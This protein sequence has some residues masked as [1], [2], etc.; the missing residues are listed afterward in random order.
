MQRS[1][2]SVFSENLATWSICV[3][4]IILNQLSVSN[5]SL[6]VENS[7]STLYHALNGMRSEFNFL[8]SKFRL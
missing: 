7:N 3:I 8:G 2:F 5:S 4:W 6:Y 1:V